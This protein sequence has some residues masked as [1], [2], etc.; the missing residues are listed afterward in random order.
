[1]PQFIVTMTS[2]IIE[3]DSEEEAIQWA[4]EHGGN[5]WEAA[6][7]DRLR[8][9][10]YTLVNEEGEEYDKF[11]NFNDALRMLN[12]FPNDSIVVTISTMVAGRSVE[13]YLAVF[14]HGYCD[15]MLWANTECV[16]A[17]GER[18]DT[19]VNPAW[20]QTDQKPN[21][22]I[23]A[24]DEPSQTAITE[25]CTNF[26]N[27]NAADLTAAYEAT[28]HKYGPEQAGQDFALTRNHHGAGFWDRGLNDIGT[29][30]TEDAHIYGDSNAECYDPDI[31]KPND[32]TR[33]HLV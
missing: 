5:H 30:L 16:D 18:T 33:A 27:S 17:K 12:E 25:D 13:D 28:S 26:V 9:L 7:P 22:G 32:D 11:D 2:P 24:F 20:W 14:I 6:S 10:T 1:M 3:A 8:G 21:W 23:D 19:E 15:A 4:D 31:E 29:R